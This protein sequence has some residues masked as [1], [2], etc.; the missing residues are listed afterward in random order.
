MIAKIKPITVRGFGVIDRVSFRIVSDDC[1]TSA[2]FLFQLGRM[3]T[4][5]PIK[6][7]AL[8]PDGSPL[9]NDDGDPVELTIQPADYFVGADREVGDVTVDGQ[10]YADWSGSNKD[11]AALVISK[12]DGVQAA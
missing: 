2:V 5:S 7:P 9:L 3:V 11:I 8:K 1:E 12:I 6:R 4:P 10:E